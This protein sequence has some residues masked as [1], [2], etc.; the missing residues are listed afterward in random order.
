M[1]PR[2][3][4][5]LTRLYRGL[6]RVERDL[7]ALDPLAQEVGLEACLQHCPAI[8]ATLIR[9]MER[10]AAEARQIAGSVP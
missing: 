4:T 2:Q 6:A 3:P 10:W 1:T 7:A 5:N 9:M 8:T